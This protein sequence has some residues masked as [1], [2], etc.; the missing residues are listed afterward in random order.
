[1]MSSAEFT[2][3]FEIVG[4]FTRLLCLKWRLVRD[5]LKVLPAKIIQ[6]KIEKKGTFGVWA[7]KLKG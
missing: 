7:N 2:A 1:M 4:C 6:S 5:A 3:L